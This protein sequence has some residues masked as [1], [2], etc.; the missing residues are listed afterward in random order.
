M[1]EA[2]ARSR[3]KAP[4]SALLDRATEKTRLILGWGDDEPV[5]W[6]VVDTIERPRSTIFRLVSVGT[7]KEGA[8]IFYKVSHSPIDSSP[9]RERWENTHAEGLS[10]TP[11]LDEKLA[12]LTAGEAIT[13]SRA[14]AV[15][16][17][18]LTLVT[19]G[20]DG[21]PVGKV[22]RHFVTRARGARL[23]AAL[24]VAGRAARLI[25]DCAPP[26]IEADREVLARAIERR[27]ERARAVLPAATVDELRRR[28]TALD[29]EVLAQPGAMVYAHGDFSS[30]NILLRPDG[31]GLI[32]FTWSPRM[33]GFDV[34]HLAFRVAYETGASATRTDPLVAA[35]L[36]GYGDP[37]LPDRPNWWAVRLPRLL[38]L[39]ELGTGPRQVR[40]RRGAER[41]VSEI[42]RFLGRG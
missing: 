9:R 17:A 29:D 10:R 41:A 20:V 7:T 1:T 3:P 23:V 31:I 4:D 14:L 38:K 13:F 2:D 35:L 24:R 11:A 37:G 36:A 6:R 39:V 22:S 27:T 19:L 26:G 5:S 33:R 12:G 21:A 32:D 8:E 15:D 25:E 40:H 28:M 42:E 18:T 16:P 34:A 30:S